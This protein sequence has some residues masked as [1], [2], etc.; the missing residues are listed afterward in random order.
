MNYKEI[1]NKVLNNIGELKATSEILTRIAGDVTDVFLQDVH[2]RSEAPCKNVDYTLTET[3]TVNLGDPPV[4]TVVDWNEEEMP[5][6][7]YIPLEVKFA[8]G[9]MIVACNELTAEEFLLWNPNPVI[10]SGDDIL[11]EPV[12]ISVNTFKYTELNR[13]DGSIGYYFEVIGEKII[14][15]WKPKIACTLS[16]RYAYVPTLNLNDEQP[17]NI[18]RMFTDLLVNGATVRELRRRL[19]KADNQFTYLAIKDNI[20]MYYAEFNRLLDRY[21]GWTKRKADTPRI[22]PFSNFTD[23]SMELE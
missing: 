6:D 11:A 9:D 16:I 3:H 5:A 22:L 14:L 2:G 17:I 20:N 15:H 8:Q 10:S 19:L 1:Y 4:P 7:F 23:N 18:H 13:Y 12:D 21:I